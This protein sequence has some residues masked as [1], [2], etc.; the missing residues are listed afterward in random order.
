MIDL[1]NLEAWFVTGSQHLYGPETLKKVEDHAAAIARA[2]AGSSQIPVKMALKPVMTSSESIH[3]LCLDA[4]N[5][6]NCIGLITWMHTFSPAR[7]W[8]AGLRSLDKPMLHLHTQ[9]NEQLPWSTIDMDFMNLNQSA[10]GDR[11]FGF[12]GARMRLKR[13]VIV[14]FW[15]D[16]AVHAELGA[17]IRAAC[18]WHDAQQLK[19]ARF[20]DNMRNVAVTEGNKVSAEI[21]LGYSVNGYGVGD[22]VRHVQQVTEAEIERLTAEYDETYAVAQSLRPGGNRRQSMRDAARIELGLRAFLEETGSFAFTDSFED[23]PGLEQLPGIAVQRLMALGYGFGAEGDWKTAALLRAVKVMGQG[24]EGGASF[25][26]DYTYHLANGGQVL[27]AHMLEVCPSI[28]EGTPSAEVHPLSIG[29][30]EDPVRL[31]FTAA[32]GNAVNASLVD[33]GNRF[34]LIV[35]QVNLIRPEHSLPKLP[36]ARAVWVPEPDLKVSATAWILAGGAHHTVLSRALT[37]EHLENFAEIAGMELLLIDRD[38]KVGDF[39]K[40]LRWN[41]LYYHLAHGL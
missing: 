7:M 20:G 36:V 26:E 5:A 12:I 38:T 6:R 40:E 17:W 34:R 41:D 14:G 24:L 1:S 27:G 23:L 16:A 25:M 21:K 9:F 22:L 3:Q 30:K 13:K 33:V 37:A 39:A 35:N 18:A 11:E 32:P 19:V 4:N 15:Q 2:F 31:V 8:I 28:A 10:H 29:G